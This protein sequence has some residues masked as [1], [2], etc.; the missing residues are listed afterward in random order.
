MKWM[1][2]QL[3]FLHHQACQ[4]AP[5]QAQAPFLLSLH[6]RPLEMGK[7][8]GRWLGIWTVEHVLYVLWSLVVGVGPV[9]I[10]TIGHSLN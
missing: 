3:A 5:L 9:W 7:Q 2:T 10:D 1:D 8:V 4:Q 6:G